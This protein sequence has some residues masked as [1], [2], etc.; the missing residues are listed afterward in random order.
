MTDLSITA[1]AVALVESP[2]Q[3]RTFPAG[4]AITAGM[5]VR[6][7]SSG[8]VVGADGGAAGTTD[9]IGV[10]VTGGAIGQGITVAQADAIIDVGNA[11]S[12]LAIGALV[13]VSDTGTN[14]GVM[15]DVAGTSS[16]TVGRVIPA[17]G[18]TTA[19]KLIRI[20]AL[21]Y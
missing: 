19:D 7:N 6:L 21:D 4:V 16:R 17:F 20:A 10:A 18:A 1:S 3:P 9:I 11:L 14:V 5:V 8:A 15:G 13:Y 2:R 12:A